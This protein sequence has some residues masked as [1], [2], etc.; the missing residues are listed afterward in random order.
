MRLHSA[1]MY[2]HWARPPPRHVGPLLLASA[3][4]CRTATAHIAMTA[5]SGA[6][7]RW[8]GYAHARRH[9]ACNFFT[10]PGDAQLPPPEL[11]EGSGGQPSTTRRLLM[12]PPY[13]YPVPP[14][15]SQYCHHILPSTAM[16]TPVPSVHCLQ[17]RHVSPL[18]PTTTS[19][20]P[21]RIPQ[22]I[23]HIVLCTVLLPPVPAQQCLHHTTR[24]PASPA[25]RSQSLE[26]RL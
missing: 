20:I 11:F 22:F 15:V 1:M 21:P 3:S 14:C 24:P 8:L 9:C 26:W 25:C 17:R 23:H 18:T 6:E 4:T 5:T 19:P 10:G 7:V 16:C 2:R 13:C 12:L